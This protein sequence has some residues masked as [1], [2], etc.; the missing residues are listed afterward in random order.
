MR[1]TLWLVVLS[2]LAVVPTRANAEPFFDLFA[3]AVFTDSNDVKISVPGFSSTS[4]SDFKTSFSVGGRAGYWFGP[5]GLNLDVNYFRP[6]LD[7]DVA[8]SGGV[9]IKT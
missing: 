4:R 7:P 3:G 6:E 5:L 8:T 1:K 2:L 9:T